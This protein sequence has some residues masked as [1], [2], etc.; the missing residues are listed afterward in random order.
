MSA[1]TVEY[2]QEHKEYLD[3]LRESGV[4]NMFGA[5]AYLQAE[6]GITK[7]D[8]NRILQTWMDNFGKED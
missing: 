1:D 4:T 7:Y 3:D 5:G 8:A 6:F 2:G